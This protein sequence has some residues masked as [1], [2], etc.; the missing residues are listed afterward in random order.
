M[1][2]TF[3]S[4]ITDSTREILYRDA[5]NEALRQEMARDETIIIMGEEISGAAG[6]DQFVGAWGG[7]FRTT[8]GLYKEFGR[9]RVLDTPISEAAF[10]GAAIGAASTGMR[11]I[12]E[13]MFVD[14]VGVCLDQLT[15]NAAKM[16]YMFGGQVKVP[17]TVMTR[18]GAGFGSAAQHSESYY[19]ILSHIPGLKGVVP[20]DAY[21][22]KGLLT[23]AIRDD[24]PVVY[25]EHKG[26]Y[27]NMGLVPEEPYVLPLGKARTVRKGTDVTL[28][29]ISRMTL[30]CVEAAQELAASGIDAEVIDLLSV[31]PI[32]Y[33]HVIDSVRRTHRLVVVDEDTPICSIASDI[34]ARVA[35]EAFDYLDAPPSRVTAPHTP[36]PYSRALEN[37]YIPNEARVVSTVRTL[38]ARG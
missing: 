32:D 10:I 8:G 33:D 29:G 37:I 2:T 30:V 23:A 11:T 7:P 28:V 26:L 16:R 38:L 14:F 25:F 9:E 6:R 36:V 1:A 15:N 31:S 34:C 21:T 13:L 20:S 5:V 18:I 27:G 22:A 35:E 12:A 24:D 4:M 3:A 17:I 19:S